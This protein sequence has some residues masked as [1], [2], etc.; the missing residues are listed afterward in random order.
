MYETIKVPIK[1]M[2]LAH[3][4]NFFIKKII[5]GG[6]GAIKFKRNI[7]DQNKNLLQEPNYGLKQETNHR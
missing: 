7:H 6:K 4:C 1:A 2:N 5:I 3:S